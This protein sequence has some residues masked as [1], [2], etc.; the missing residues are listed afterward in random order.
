MSF[1]MFVWLR[2][3][4]GNVLRALHN[5]VFGCTKLHSINTVKVDKIRVLLYSGYIHMYNAMQLLFPNITCETHVKSGV[6]ST[7]KIETNSKLLPVWQGS[8][9]ILLSSINIACLVYI[10]WYWGLVETCY[11]CVTWCW[12]YFLFDTRKREWQED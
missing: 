4:A 1:V 8:F 12:L 10:I 11:Q 6:T 9:L 2:N 3:T 7:L 5:V